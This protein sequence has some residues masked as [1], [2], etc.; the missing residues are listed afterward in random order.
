MAEGIPAA[1]FV[2]GE[3]WGN[4]LAIGGCLVPMLRQKTLLSCL[5]RVVIT[6]LKKFPILLD[7]Q[8]QPDGKAVVQRDQ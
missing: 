3:H 1:D 7:G 4:P 8:L 6:A 5:F 2:T